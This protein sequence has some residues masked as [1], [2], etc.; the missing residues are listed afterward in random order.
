MLLMLIRQYTYISAKTNSSYKI[1][2]FITTADNPQSHSIAKVVENCSG[3][4]KYFII[5]KKRDYRE[6]GGIGIENSSRFR[7]LVEIPLKILQYWR[8]EIIFFQF[9]SATSIEL[10]RQT[11]AKSKLRSPS[12]DLYKYRF[13]QLSQNME[14]MQLM[15]QAVN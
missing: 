9:S 12:V 15:L 3:L 4:K 11:R 8:P 5:K 7:T 2:V 13:S 6:P 10:F 14:N 1:L